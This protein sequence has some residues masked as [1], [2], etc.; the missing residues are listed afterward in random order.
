MELESVLHSVDEKKLAQR[1]KKEF[2]SL[3]DNEF[4]IEGNRRVYSSSGSDY[5][6]KKN[7]PILSANGNLSAIYRSRS[8]SKHGLFKD[9]KLPDVVKEELE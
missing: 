8:P 2:F 5:V 9:I 1:D 7:M 6:L 3:F 4:V